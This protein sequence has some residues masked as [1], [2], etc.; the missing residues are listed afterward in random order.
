MTQTTVRIS[1]L[2]ALTNYKILFL[3]T[4]F[5]VGAFS[6]LMGILAAFGASTVTWNGESVYGLSGLVT[7]TLLGAAS[8]IF[9]T[10]VLGSACVLGTWLYSKFESISITYIT[11]S[12]S[13]A[14]TE[15]VSNAAEK[16]AA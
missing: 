5:S 7:G 6:V 12:G 16:S 9:T 11:T 10:V 15:E 13:S 8:S 14:S 1:R 3:G 2:S 4:S